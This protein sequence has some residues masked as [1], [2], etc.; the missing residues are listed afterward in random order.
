MIL[1]GTIGSLVSATRRRRN[2]L[3]ARTDRLAPESWRDQAQTQR[4]VADLARQ[5]PSKSSIGDPVL[6]KTLIS[7]TRSLQR[8]LR[9]ALELT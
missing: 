1:V 4:A 9:P 8:A 3:R 6:R 2:T 7:R 5:V